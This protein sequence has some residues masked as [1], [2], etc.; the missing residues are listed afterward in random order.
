MKR[1]SENIFVSE[2]L[3]INLDSIKNRIPISFN[4]SVSL[5]GFLTNLVNSV[6]KWFLSSFTGFQ[7]LC[8][9][10]FSELLI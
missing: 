6:R 10:A 7:A 3:N 4:L 1:K 9:S 5:E 2:I 8:L